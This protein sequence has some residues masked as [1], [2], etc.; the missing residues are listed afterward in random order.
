MME[1]ESNKDFSRKM[2]RGM[3]WYTFIEFQNSIIFIIWGIYLLD[4]F[5]NTFKNNFN[6]TSL[7]YNDENGWGVI[8]ILFGF[9]QCIAMRKG[10]KMERLMSLYVD[11]FLWWH[12]TTEFFMSNK[13]SVLGPTCAVLWLFSFLALA[14][15]S[16]WWIEDKR[17]NSDIELV[18]QRCPRPYCDIL[19][20]PKEGGEG[21]GS[22]GADGLC[23][24]SRKADQS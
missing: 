3:K 5:I 22:K 20:N 21:A 9:A 13:S 23:I 11:Q 7:I 10:S 6:Y 2:W 14:R 15:I 19:V 1:S 16:R 12:W 18:G 8:L 17:P 24:D 4:P